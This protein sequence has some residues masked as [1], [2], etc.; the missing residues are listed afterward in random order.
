TVPMNVAI[1]PT[2]GALTAAIWAATSNGSSLTPASCASSRSLMV[3]P[4]QLVENVVE[5]GREHRHPVANAARRSGQV[6]HEALPDGAGAP[7]AQHGGGERLR[8]L[9]ADRFR[10]TGQFPFEHLR[11]AFRGE[12]ERSDA[13]AAGGDDD[14]RAGASRPSECV[15]NPV[16]SV[17]NNLRGD[18]VAEV[19]ELLHGNRP[20]T[21][22]F[23]L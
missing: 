20:P 18:V 22:I 4:H 2:S 7:T 12:V 9:G 21:T 3:A 10:D 6:A 13:R 5:H 17:V 15:S 1:P 14:P 11:C 23:K 16:G 8:A 19:G